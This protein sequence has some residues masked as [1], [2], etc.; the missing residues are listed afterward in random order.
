MRSFSTSSCIEVTDSSALSFIE[1][2]KNHTAKASRQ[3]GDGRSKQALPRR[4]VDILIGLTARAMGGSRFAFARA[5]LC[6]FAV[7][8]YFGTWLNTDIFIT[9]GWA[10]CAWICCARFRWPKP[11]IMAVVWQV[12]WAGISRQTCHGVFWRGFLCQPDPYQRAALSRWSVA[13]DGRVHC[14]PDYPFEHR[15]QQQKIS[16]SDRCNIWLPTSFR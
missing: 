7:P 2:G 13:L 6:T 14:F 12:R 5:C 1:M 8:Q 11:G 3:R 10:A 16:C 4:A 15:S 9:L